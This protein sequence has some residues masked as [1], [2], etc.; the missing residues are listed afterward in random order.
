MI[1]EETL[2][3]SVAIS[4]DQEPL[5]HQLMKSGLS[6]L[7]PFLEVNERN[8]DFSTIDNTKSGRGNVRSDT[9]RATPI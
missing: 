9:F 1:K 6:N 7:V 4:T 2:T 5:S 8:G 3:P